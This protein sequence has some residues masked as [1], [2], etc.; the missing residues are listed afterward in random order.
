MKDIATI[1]NRLK[2]IEY[3]TSLSLLEVETGSMSLKDPQTNLD[4]FQVWFL[5]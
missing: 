4:R 1:E 2:N 3:Y 5:C